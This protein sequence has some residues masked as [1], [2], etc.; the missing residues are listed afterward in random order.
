[1]P[2][3][4]G[5]PGEF[6][7]PALA[8]ADAD[9]RIG[10]DHFDLPALGAKAEHRFRAGDHRAAAAYYSMVA[11]VAEQRGPATGETGSVAAR[12]I[13]MVDWLTRR[14]RDHVTAAL[15]QA[16]Y[17]L[18]ARPARFQQALEMLMGQRLR[19]PVIENFPQLP[20]LFYYPGLP[21]VDFVDPEKFEW[22]DQL[23]ACFPAMREE[24]L[25]LLAEQKGF[26][27]YVTKVAN[28]PQGD[29][30]GLLE[31]SDWSSFYLWQNGR[32][33]EQNAARCPA[34]FNGLTDNV[35]L[36]AVANRS[37][38]AYLSLLKPGAHIPTH[39]GMFNC[40]YICHLPLVVPPDCRLRVG[41]RT[42]E[43]IEGKL[44]VFDDS[45]EHEAW[46]RSAQDR[47]I[48]LF[49]VWNPDLTMSERELVRIMLE[50]VDS[51]S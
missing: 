25:A 36:F 35:P 19:D 17:P 38:S 16:G 42:A 50:A 15:D 14:F 4:A 28:R 51:Y 1:M 47:L 18:E 3:E 23:E 9:A 11:S 22:A 37:P 33:V 8:E 13:A 43:W 12:A 27:P 24:A 32:P 5:A 34:I 40:R 20:K 31:N 41:A 44:L 6:P 45:V 39:T 2:S 10:R 7:M 29:A 21:K 26:A 30:H 46:N 49:E 48:L